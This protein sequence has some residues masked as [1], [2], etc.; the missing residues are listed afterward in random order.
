[1]SKGKPL[2]PLKVRVDHLDEPK[3]E[4]QQ[5]Q[6][7]EYRQYVGIDCHSLRPPQHPLHILHYT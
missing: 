3:P 5:Q 2:F 6:R 1:M 4:R 7:K